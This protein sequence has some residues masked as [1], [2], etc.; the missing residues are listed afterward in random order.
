[1]QRIGFAPQKFS[2]VSGAMAVVDLPMS[3]STTVFMGLWGAEEQ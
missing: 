2:P 3:I 1:M